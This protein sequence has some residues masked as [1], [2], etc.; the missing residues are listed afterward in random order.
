MGCDAAADGLRTDALRSRAAG[1]LRA[2]GADCGWPAG[3]AIAPAG[4]G[5]REP[6]AQAAIRA[7][8]C[9]TPADGLRQQPATA[10]LAHPAALY[11]DQPGLMVWRVR[12][13]LLC[14]AR[15]GRARIIPA[16][17][18]GHVCVRRL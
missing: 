14:A 8:D 3:A 2:A 5:D 1:L 7:E 10:L 6:D 4:A 16:A 9:A 18:A 11:A 13:V 12:G 17:P 15:P